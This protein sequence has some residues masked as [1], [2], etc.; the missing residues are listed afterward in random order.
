MCGI[1]LVLTIS[2]QK[3]YENDRSRSPLAVCHRYLQRL[4]H[5][6]RQG[7]KI[8]FGTFGESVIGGLGCVSDAIP[9][10]MLTK[11]NKEKE[12]LWAVGHTRYTTSGGHQSSSSSSMR[13]LQPFSFILDNRYKIIFAHNG[14]LGGSPTTYDQLKKEL[15]TS[16]HFVTDSDTELFYAELCVNTNRKDDIHARIQSAIKNIR[17]SASLVGIVMDILTKSVSAFACRKNGNRPLFSVVSNHQWIVTSEDYMCRDELCNMDTHTATIEEI[18]P[19]EYVQYHA[20]SK[21]S[22]YT[23]MKQTSRL[24]PIADPK[25]YC[26]F[27]LFYFSHPLST[28]LGVH[29]SQIRKEFGRVLYQEHAQL[30]KLCDPHRS[31]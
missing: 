1:C 12:D 21:N 22:N 26:I 11:I 23:W 8:H 25:R 2:D 10:D 18:A 17:G 3:G 28:F 24:C 4:Q 7:A 9:T 30:L 16:Y 27:E 19:G 20:D 6:G 13:S 29:I 14:Q 5:R 15:E 31:D